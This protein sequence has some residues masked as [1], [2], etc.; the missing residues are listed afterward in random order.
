MCSLFNISTRQYYITIKNNE[1]PTVQLLSTPPS[2]QLL[3]DDEENHILSQ[4]LVH[5]VVNDCLTSWDIRDM[6]SDIY[7]IKTC[8]ERSFSRDWARIFLRRHFDELE[9]IKTCSID[10]DR[11]NIDLEEVQ[12]YIA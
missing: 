3:L 7:K 6:A 5:Q 2:Q 10:D 11:A 1:A 9:K 12:R 4:I 8:K